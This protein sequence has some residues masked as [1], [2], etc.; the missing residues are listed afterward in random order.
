MIE[1]GCGPGAL[2]YRHQMDRRGENPLT[3]TVWNLIIRVSDQ[4]KA[5]EIKLNE[6]IPEESAA[7][8]S[9]LDEV[10]NNAETAT[11]VRNP[12]INSYL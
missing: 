3:V 4:L 11:Q 6:V 1:A 7:A 2:Y 5:G 8:K 12:N 10:R 9:R